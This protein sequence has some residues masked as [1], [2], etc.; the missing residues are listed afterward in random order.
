MRLRAGFTLIEL[1]VVMAVIALLVVLLMPAMG[2]VSEASRRARCLSNLRQLLLATTLEARE[3]ATGHY[4]GTA[5]RAND[6]LN[7]L[8]PEY[9]SDTRIAICP[10]TVN[11]VDPRRTATVGDRT[12]LADL[13]QTA[14]YADD[15]EGG[16]SYEIWDWF[17]GPTVYPDGT[18]VEQTQPKTI[19]NT[20]G[21]AVSK[22]GLLLDGDDPFLPGE[23]DALVPGSTRHFP[24]SWNNH[25][26]EGYNIAYLDGHARFVPADRE[27][28]RMWMDSYLSV[29]MPHQFDEY[30]KRGALDPRG[31]VSQRGGV[32]GKGMSLHWAE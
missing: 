13:R 31:Q 29:D 16:H 32:R 26:A 6:D 3:S 25:G 19:S 18:F 28:V 10:S 24:D 2:R 12:V 21:F 7:L 17:E 23:T 4:G 22:I 8:I 15:S 30:L 20:S 9:A 1:V 11:L 5:N 14:R 27:L